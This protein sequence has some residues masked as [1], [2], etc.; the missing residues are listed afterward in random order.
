[1]C[2]T[3]PRPSWLDTTDVAEKAFPDK[4][5][6]TVPLLD[7]S[8]VKNAW[9]ALKDDKVL[10]KE[11]AACGGGIERSGARMLRPPD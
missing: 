1:M 3:K 9:N 4:F 6:Q 2:W 11:D 7:R 10:T 5:L 8:F